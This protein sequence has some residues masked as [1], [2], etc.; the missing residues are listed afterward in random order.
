MEW[1]E[2]KHNLELESEK[3]QE[4]VEEKK[5]LQK[6]HELDLSNENRLIE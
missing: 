4:E 6:E 5:R 1:V 3:L 2:T